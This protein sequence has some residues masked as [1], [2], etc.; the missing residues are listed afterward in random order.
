MA[1]P[2]RV[3]RVFDLN[4]MP[5][6]PCAGNTLAGLED[7]PTGERNCIPPPDRAEESIAAGSTWLTGQEAFGQRGLPALRWCR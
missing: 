6:A 2:P 3:V 7:R 5:A 1:G 4:R